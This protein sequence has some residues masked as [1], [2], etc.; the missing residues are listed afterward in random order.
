MK[1]G[2]HPLSSLYSDSRSLWVSESIQEYEHS[3]DAITFL[4]DHVGQSMPCVWR[5]AVSNWDAIRKW[6]KS[7][8]RYLREKI[9]NREV[10]VAVTPD[11]RADAVLEVRAPSG[12]DKKV[13]AM[14]HQ[15]R[16]PFELL[17]DEIAD[18][19]VRHAA[20][21]CPSEVDLH[22]PHDDCNGVPYYSAQDASLTREVP[23]L[24]E[25][26]DVN[27]I[28]FAK[29]AFGSEESAINIWLG[30][31]RSLT[32]MHSD[33]FENLY[34][35][36][37]GTKIFEL[38]PPCD[39][40]FLPKPSLQRVRWTPIE[41]IT[42]EGMNAIQAKKQYDGWTLVKEEGET[43]WIDED[44]IPKRWGQAMTVS[45]NPG[46]LLYL[47]GLWCKFM[48]NIISCSAFSSHY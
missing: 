48:S 9:G 47:P 14:P 18:V 3:G 10:E 41:S 36:V 40:A 43:E 22:F 30:D 13:F 12:E 5:G 29:T 31:G 28:D 45:L 23:E 33:P 34:A 35:V 7:E 19:P 32:T 42:H 17:L 38:R 39:A 16:Q 8:F 21:Q 26:I 11:G 44:S 6:P 1:S 2:G 4:R 20:L 37:V 27:I 46:D 24:L 15:V 25:D